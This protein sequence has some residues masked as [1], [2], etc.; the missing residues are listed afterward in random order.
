MYTFNPGFNSVLNEHNE[1]EDSNM[2]YLLG[3]NC[4]EEAHI[5]IIKLMTCYWYF[6]WII[7]G[8][9]YYNK[10]LILVKTNYFFKTFKIV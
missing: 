5:M 8:G 9:F 10:V 6:D 3:E 2:Y 7:H 4:F 1:T